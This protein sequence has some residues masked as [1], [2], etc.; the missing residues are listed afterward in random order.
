MLEP[1]KLLGPFRIEEEIGSGAMGTVFRAVHAESGKPVAIKIVSTGLF[2]N[3][4]ARARF[5]R[6]GEILKQLKH[7]HIV[8]LFATGHYKKTP[9]LAMEFV[10][11]EALDVALERRGRLT[12]EE[13]VRYAKQLCLA[14]THAHEKGIIHRDLKPSNLIILKDGTLKLADFGIAKDADVT[15]LT[16]QNS[17]VGTAAYMSPEQCRGERNLTAKSDLYSLGVCLYE[18]LTGEKPFVRDSAVD[19]FMAHV[20]DPFERPGRKVLDIP[21]W[22]DTLVCQ[23]ME[24]KPEHRPLDA[25]MVYQALDQVL[26]KVADQRSAGVELAKSRAVDRTKPLTADEHDKEAARLLRG[27]K[28]KSK[29]RGA[30]FYERGWFVALA[31]IFLLAGFGW[32]MIWALGPPSADTLYARAKPLMDANKHG[33]ATPILHQYYQ[34][35]ANRGD[36]QARTMRTWL[37]EVEVAE[38][39]RGI[40]NRYRKDWKAEDEPSQQAYA[41]YRREDEG[42]V[43]EARK[44]WLAMA[45]KYQSAP[46]L[47]EVKWAWLG[48]KKAADL[49]R[50]P[51]LQQHLRKTWAPVD[52]IT[53]TEAERRPAEAL[54]LELFGDLPA[55]LVRWEKVRNESLKEHDGRQYGV[56]AA[57]KVRELS[58]TAVKGDDEIREFR[59]AL[60]NEQMKIVEDLAAEGVPATIRQAHD[61][62]REIAELYENDA[63]PQVAELGKKAAARLKEISRPAPPKS[64]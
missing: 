13:V 26:D 8:R 23:L 50:F 35:Y 46:S 9:F 32:F 15:A 42:D 27:S 24:K 34:H 59:I 43:A 25:A 11:G 1:G 12:W 53:A 17:T 64:N 39:E 48:E 14:L 57:S 36:E 60:I 4:S 47:D 21:P 49:D 7:P 45:A 41:A 38:R 2:A 62:C 31:A 61:L 3:E 55:A 22:L 44:L 29:K 40:F 54:R 20:N 51:E 16:G 37:K 56:L 28:K 58:E 52:P 6:E 63:N 33:D 19:M 18:L 30:A 10:D 5:E